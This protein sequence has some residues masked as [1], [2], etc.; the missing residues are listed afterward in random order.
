MKVANNSA[1]FI[2][3]F[4][5]NNYSQSV[6]EAVINAIQAHATNINVGMDKVLDMKTNLRQT[7]NKFVGLK[8]KTT[9][10][11]LQKKIVKQ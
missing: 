5:E 6:I 8:L 9:A 1:Y 3:K 4:E 11:D 2:K 7:E 10:M